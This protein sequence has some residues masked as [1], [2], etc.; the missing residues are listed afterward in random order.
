MGQ[1]QYFFKRIAPPV[2]SDLCAKYTLNRKYKTATKQ[3]FY[4][5]K[6]HLACGNNILKGWENIDFFEH[7]QVVFCDLTK[8]FPVSENSVE[9]I[10]CEHFIE[11]IDLNQ[12]YRFLKNCYDVLKS[13][14]SIRI[15]TPNLNKVVHCYLEKKLTEWEDVGFVPQTPCVLLNDSL[16]LWGHQFVYDEDELKQL[17]HSVGFKNIRIM[18]WHN[19]E[20]DEFVGLECR[21]YHDDLIFEAD[22]E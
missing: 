21:P 11:H 3:L 6:L 22:K 17:L 14:G 4:A 1:L 19:S 8:K 10:Y 18:P 13:S 12:G 7:P 9:Y 5:K 16:H 2:I 20:I 15:S